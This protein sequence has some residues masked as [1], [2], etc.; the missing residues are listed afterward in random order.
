MFWLYTVC[1]KT[2][3]PVFIR[4]QGGPKQRFIVKELYVG[5]ASCQCYGLSNWVRLR[6]EI[7]QNHWS[8]LKKSCTSHQFR[9]DVH[10]YWPPTTQQ[11]GM[12]ACQLFLIL[13]V[14][15]LESHLLWMT[16]SEPH[17]CVSCSQIHINIERFTWAKLAN[18]TGSVV[19]RMAMAGEGR[20]F[21][22]S[23]CRT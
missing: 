9:A 17:K 12:C 2:P 11:T 15:C 7:K 21:I 14:V 6:L 18:I 19:Q 23:V 22:T 10:K 3:Y 8:I 1:R 20:G 16:I 13:L 4:W 5:D